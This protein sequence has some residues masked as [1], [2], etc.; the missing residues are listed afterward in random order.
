MVT[1]VLLLLA[2]V[3]LRVCAACAAALVYKGLLPHRII[4]DTPEYFV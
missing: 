3:R 2:V 4:I 1:V